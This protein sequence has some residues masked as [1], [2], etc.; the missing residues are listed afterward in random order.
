MTFKC[1]VLESKIDGINNKIKF[2]QP[3]MQK[4]LMRFAQTVYLSSQIERKFVIVC[5]TASRF[6][7]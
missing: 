7:Y 2:V 3:M 1:A 5:D 6:G 4:I